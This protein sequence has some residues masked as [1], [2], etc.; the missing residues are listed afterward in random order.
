VPR[1]RLSA[2]ASTRRAAPL[3]FAASP[4]ENVDIVDGCT[5]RLNLEPRPMQ[6]TSARLPFFV[7]IAA[8][9]LAGCLTADPG[10][11]DPTNVVEQSLG[12]VHRPPVEAHYVAAVGAPTG[13]LT[14]LFLHNTARYTATVVET[15][16]ATGACPSATCT[17][18][19]AGSYFVLGNIRTNTLLLYPQT[20]A[21]GPRS[22]QM[23]AGTT[24]TSVLF[25]RAGITTE[26]FRTP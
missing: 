17:H 11:E 23:L 19:E 21:P 25:V 26:L 3:S 1:R 7:A 6:Y 18:D 4:F 5:S 9:S 20:P 24:P 22:Y 14:D 16:D 12:S 15:P 2:P 13:E 10:A 8:A